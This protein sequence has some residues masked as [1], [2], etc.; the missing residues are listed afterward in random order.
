MPLFALQ[1][2][3]GDGSVAYASLRRSSEEL[4]SLLAPR[5]ARHHLHSAFRVLDSSTWGELA[6]VDVER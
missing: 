3:S 1:T 4:G 5:R 2:F 6:T